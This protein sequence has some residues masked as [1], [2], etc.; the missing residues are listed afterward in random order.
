MPQFPG[1]ED[2]FIRS[3]RDAGIRPLE[4]SSGP[5]RRLIITIALIFALFLLLSGV[6]TRLADWLW[7][8]EIGFERVFLTKV[9]AQWAIGLL[10]GAIA[11]A[12]LYGNARFALRGWTPGRMPVRA[13][14][15]SGPEAVGKARAARLAAERDVVATMGRAVALPWTAFL[16]IMLALAMAAEWNTALQLIHRT[17]F[18]TTDPIF[19]RDVG[20]YVFVLPAIELAAG[21]AFALAMMALLLVALPAHL[22]RGEIAREP[23]RIV[24]RPR[25]Q[26]HL[27][28][29]AALLLLVVGLRTQ[30]VRVPGLLFGEHLPLTG[31]NYVDLHVRLPALHVLTV[32]ALVARR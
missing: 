6:V 10:V 12:V 28:V 19:G 21:I 4:P 25:A 23:D 17:P 15:P 3:L 9:V 32:A 22:L 24:V 26:A 11:F 13:D 30:F 1:D 8:R 29:L 2:P 18:G 14:A 7:F 27:A 5:P 31:A 16:S 20:Y